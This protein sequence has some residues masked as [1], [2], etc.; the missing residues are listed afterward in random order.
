MGFFD[1]ISNTY[2]RELTTCMKRFS[3]GQYKL[4]SLKNRRNFLISCRRQGII[5]PH[6]QH[7]AQELHTL[8][9]YNDSRTANTVQQFNRRLVN[10]V[11]SLE[12]TI[13]IKNI[14]SLSR[15][16]E[17]LETDVLVVLPHHIW[18]EYQRRMT[19][20][21]N[22]HFF[23]TK[24]RN[25]SKLQ[26]IKNSLRSKIKT[27]DSWLKNISG[28]ELPDEV[29]TLLSLGPKFS[30]EPSAKELNIPG[31]LSEIELANRDRSNQEKNSTTAR[32]TN[33]ITNYVQRQTPSNVPFLAMY[34]KTATFLKQHPEI[35][36]TPADKGSVSVVMKRDDY[37]NLSIDILQDPHSYK[38]LQRDPTSTFQQ[39][40]NS[41]ITEMK[42]HNYID[43]QTAKGLMIYN[44]VA[45][46]YYGLPKIHKPQLKL[47]PI[48]SSINC[49]NSKIA[50][51]ATNILSRAYDKN[52]RYYIKD[53]IEFSNKVN[54]SNIPY[55][56]VVVSLDVV[57]L[58]TN[59]P[60]ELVRGSIEKRWTM[61]SN[62]C[63]VNKQTFLKII[64]FI[65][66]STYFSYDNTFYKQITGTPMGAI[67]SPIL[68]Q[69]IMDDALDTCISKLPFALPFCYKYVDDVICSV[70]SDA[71]NDT[72][73]IF[74]SYHP[75]IQ[76]TIEEETGGFVPF[77][78]TKVI[79]DGTT[80]KT[81]WY[82]KPTYS[83][84]YVNHFSY[85]STKTKINVVL[86]MKNKILHVSHESFKQQNLK[87]FF[88]IMKQN[89]YPESLL[90]KLIFHT[91]SS[92]RQ[93]TFAENPEEDQPSPRYRSLPFIKPLSTKLAPLLKVSD[94]DR[95]AYKTSKTVRQLFS[96]L[97]DKTPILQQSNVVYSI[98]CL[99]CPKCY[100]GQTSRTLKARITSHKSDAR[101]NVGNCA[102]AKHINDTDHTMNY[103]E[104]KI[105][106]VEN[107]TFKRTFLEM[108]R[109]HQTTDSM[110]YRRDIENLSNMYTFLLEID[111]KNNTPQ[112]RPTQNGEDAQ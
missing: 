82:T 95:I 55:G 92:R 94:T 10:R 50:Q 72:L 71:T 25:I 29:K 22:K 44:P 100:I 108:V 41:L 65:F 84:R 81:D 98:S 11:I 38:K 3:D 91:T 7:R 111:K 103:E 24:R 17:Q 70:P 97:K 59:I 87:T 28:V 45:P 23:N 34:R 15:Y 48:I 40:A 52:N 8:F 9:Q 102:L 20:H 66:D 4:A 63:D 112:T 62:H 83:G 13:T 64:D 101:R 69:Y 6:I 110:N 54:N 47:R 109:I 107:N 89:A 58:F 51:F 68:A 27:P 73:L 19:F 37:H 26:R 86:N 104:P 2:G 12:I 57:S 53:S 76:F 85:H 31:L 96:K 30:I 80:I 1:D 88:N 78:D 35:I 36:V 21:W 99:N 42:K 74:N 32:A 16:Q 14:V 39:R 49:P 79:R 93:P 61:I 43:D 75:K 46:K 105:L 90:R 18:A 33:I 106:D 60:R 5:P 77:L 56:Y 67:I